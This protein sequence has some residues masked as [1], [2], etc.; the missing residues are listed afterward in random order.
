MQI[1]NSDR[2]IELALQKLTRTQKIQNEEQDRR[3]KQ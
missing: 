2:I 1:K 3:H